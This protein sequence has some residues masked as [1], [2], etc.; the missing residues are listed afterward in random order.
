[1]ACEDGRCSLLARSSFAEQTTAFA[2][3]RRLPIRSLHACF[4]FFELHAICT[5]EL[6]ENSLT[7]GNYLELSGNIL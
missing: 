6:L 4:F 5:M 3:L 2:G 1:M 7:S